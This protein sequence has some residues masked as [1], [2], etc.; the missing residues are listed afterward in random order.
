MKIRRDYYEAI[1]N[2]DIKFF[3]SK[4]VGDLSKY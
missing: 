3:D 2:K 1:I 4:K